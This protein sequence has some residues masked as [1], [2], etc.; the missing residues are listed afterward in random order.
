MKNPVSSYNPDIL[1][2]DF[3]QMTIDQPDDYE[4]KV[5]CTLIRK[6]AINAT[7]KAVLY[8]HGFNDYF[9]QKGMAE[10]FTGNGFDFY[11][12]DL[13]KYG[14]SFLPHQKL[15]NLRD[16]K[17]YYADLDS[18]LE[19]IKNEGHTSVLLSGHSTG[20]LVVSVYAHDH[21]DSKLF[22]SIFLNS[23]FYD[24][25][26]NFFLRKLA[27]PIVSTLGKNNPDKI[28]NGGFSPLYGLSI[29][30]GDKGEWEYQLGWKPHVAPA[31]NFGFIRA[32]HLAQ[33]KVKNGVNINV[34]V[35]VM[36]SKVSLYEKEWS[37]K[38]FTGDAILNVKHI[39]ENAQKIQ[40][41][42]TIQAV[43]GGMHD[44]ILSPKPVREKV[45][46]DLFEWL[47]KF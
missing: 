25:N 19:Q 32:I 21:Q 7:P 6:K 29:Y 40:G 3:E 20:G 15:N 46:F 14:R 27:I 28:M 33:E 36:H 38:L 11:A 16:I 47:K 10:K 18:A 30:K 1:G 34:P 41:K 8:V 24:F 26:S 22:H 4:G 13:R 17:E 35:L 45:Y 37:D 12:I 5:V 9:F 43:E 2:S 39:S 31:V 44:L 23:P 42:V